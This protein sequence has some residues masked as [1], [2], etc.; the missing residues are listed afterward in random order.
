MK[1]TKQNPK[2]AKVA[3]HAL[4]S[5]YQ[6]VKH[7]NRI[8][9]ANTSR[10]QAKELK[11]ATDIIS[12]RLKL[13]GGLLKLNMDADSPN[14]KSLESSRKHMKSRQFAKVVALLSNADK[15]VLGLLPGVIPENVLNTAV[16]LSELTT[17]LQSTVSS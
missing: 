9:E 1:T 12:E 6:K 5:T 10:E 3:G 7:F 15:V 2:D 4:V 17:T 16:K 11:Q 13:I 14:D 8:L